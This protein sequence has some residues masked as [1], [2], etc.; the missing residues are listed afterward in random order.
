MRGRHE[1][2]C[3]VAARA[4]HA[5]HAS[6]VDSGGSGCVRRQAPQAART[7]RSLMAYDGS[8]Y[9]PSSAGSSKTG[10]LDGFT[11]AEHQVVLGMQA[12]Q[13]APNCSRWCN[14]MLISTSYRGRRLR[15]SRAGSRAQVTCTT[16]SCGL[17]AALAVGCCW[18]NSKM[19]LDGDGGLTKNPMP[20]GA[21]S[22]CCGRCGR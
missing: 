19:A 8:L 9:A 12:A 2:T 10:R 1:P 13:T 20:A 4:R 15:D 5:R 21:A 22:T 14:S 11:S 6:S 17:K 7:A 16:G 18:W 3:L